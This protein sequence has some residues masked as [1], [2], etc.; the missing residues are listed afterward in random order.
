LRHPN[1][2][3]TTA[4]IH[5]DETKTHPLHTIISTYRN[6]SKKEAEFISDMQTAVEDITANSPQTTVTIIGD[7]NIDLLKLTPTSKFTHFMLENNL[8]TTITTPTRY[9]TSSAA[10][11]LIDVVL[12]T[13]T[14]APAT[15][16]TISP[17]LSDHLPIYTTFHTT[18]PQRKQRIEKRL[19]NSQYERNKT[20]ILE[21]AT[22]AIAAAEQM[23]QQQDT[24]TADQFSQLQQALQKVIESFE[25]RP[26][27]RR[28]PWCDPKIRKMIRKQHKLHKTR[29]L[30][31]TAI[32]IRRHK[33]YR[34]QLIRAIRAKKR[35]FLRQ[36]LQ[37]T[38]GNPRKQNQILQKLLPKNSQARATPA[39]VSYKGQ[40]YRDP[41]DIANALNDHFIT[42]G[43][44][45]SQTIPKIPEDQQPNIQA[46]QLPAFNLQRT[47]VEEVA[48]LLAKLDRNKA[49][50]I[51]KIKPTILRDLLTH[52]A[53][54][55]TQ[56][57]NQAIDEHR[58]PDP[59]KVTK[60][61]ELFKA[62]DAT[63]PANYRPISLLPIIAKVFDTLI[64]NQIMKHLLEHDI[65]SPTQYAFRPHSSTVMALQTI[66]NKILKHKTAKAAILA[67]YIDLSKAYDTILHSK[68]LHKLRHQFNF[69]ESTVAF[70]KSYF[71]NRQQ[72]T[73]TQ[74]AKSKTLTITHGIPQGS[75]LSTTF[76]LL[77]INDIIKSVPNS[78][79][80]TF[81]DDTTLVISANSMLSL[82]RIAQSELNNLI[83]YF[84]TNN[85]VPNP[86]KTNYTIFHPPAARETI[87]L[88]IGDTTLIHN[89]HAKLLGI[90]IE[91]TLKHHLTITNTISKLQP[92]IQALR[93]AS[94]LLPQ[95]NMI[96]L[97]YSHIY[98]HLIYSIAIWG[99]DNHTKTYLQPLILIQKKIIRIILNKPPRTH[100]KPLMTKHKILNITNLYIQRVC[101]E[102]HPYIHNN[103]PKHRPD[104]DHNYIW[105]AQIHEYPTRHALKCP[106][107][108]IEHL[109]EQYAAIWNA[110]PEKLRQQSRLLTFKKKLREH[111]LE[112][113]QL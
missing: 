89:L 73:H 82:Q 111:L 28:K 79:V 70:I 16:G 97:Y 8:H 86:T 22:R 43:H 64:N 14:Q 102:T 100:T 65:L 72:S 39:V 47:S 113:Q 48:Q 5:R 36:R 17:P 75:T 13:N 91:N 34:N 23:Q 21:A 80:Y 78:S 1:T 107:Y 109:T 71:E 3:N 30:R 92:I 12:T 105:V 54:K 41:K 29:L 108:S 88:N 104:H 81:A 45:T 94:R 60:V 46:P 85:L 53:P 31:P 96:Q 67:I 11:T 62:K 55:L 66:I 18:P 63:S 19:S 4:Q 44:R 112:K 9:N 42:I 83:T 37:A 103:N 74:H 87:Q 77:Y 51:Y 95:Q 101:M 90:I 40:E 52:L 110:L 99:S 38:Q 6:P 35:T 15:A 69:T 26:K 7:I 98:P 56:L 10:S 24:T 57:Y 106:V 84:H 59:L 49:N 32:N 25:I 76:F 33:Q 20:K 27:P 61:I 93:Y 68:L 58:Y 2:P 50:D